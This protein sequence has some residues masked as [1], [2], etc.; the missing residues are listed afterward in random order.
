MRKAASGSVI[1]QL[2]AFAFLAGTLNEGS[3]LRR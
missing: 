1:E 3:R 2:A